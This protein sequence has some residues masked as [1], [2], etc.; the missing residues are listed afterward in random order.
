MLLTQRTSGNRKVRPSGF[1]LVELLAVMLILTVL[2]TLV[3]GGARLVTAHV[4][5]EETKSSMKIIMSAI[6]EYTQST[7][8]TPGSLG[9]LEGNSGAKELISKLGKK[10]WDGSKFFDAWGNEIVYSSNGGL[11]GGPGLTSGGPD[12]DTSTD[13]DNV[14][15]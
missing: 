14:R 15:Q 11:G 5:A 1:T 4:Y 10:A 13:E 7:G 3:V 6:S 2:L 9:N 12:G 8:S